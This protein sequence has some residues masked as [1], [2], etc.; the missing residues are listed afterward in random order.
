MMPSGLCSDI[1]GLFRNSQIP[2]MSDR[3]VAIRRMLQAV[4]SRNE[5]LLF[6]HSVQNMR[7]TKT[8]GS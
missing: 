1:N 3:P 6:A 4:E 7:M 8:P 2:G 5:M